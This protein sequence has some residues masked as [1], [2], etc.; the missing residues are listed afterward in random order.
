MKTILTMIAVLALVLPGM[1]QSGAAAG[2]EKEGVAVTVYN[3]GFGV[4][5]DVR[6]L[7]VGKDGVVLFKDVA[8]QIDS[9]TVHFKSFDDP[10]AKLLEQNYQYDLVSSDKLLQKYIDKEIEV[11]AAPKGDKGE[12]NRYAGKLLSFDGA[13]LVLQEKAG[14][15]VMVQRADNVR[16]I[17]F[18]ALPEGL[19]T[20]PTLVW[21][22]ATQKPG[23]QLAEVSYQTNG[24]TW[25]SEY[26]MVLNADD[27]AAGLN[28][29]VSV[30]NNS[31]KTYKDAHMKFIAGDVRRIQPPMEYNRRL[32]AM[33]AAAKP[34]ESGMVE[35]AFFEYHMYSLKRPSTVANN[36]VKQLELFE[37]VP[38]L[39]VQKLFLY[40]PMKGWRWGGGRSTEK[41][42][43]VTSDKKVTVF[44]EFENTKANN[45]GIPLPAG[46]VRV[47]KNDPADKSM[48][49]VGEEQIDHTANG[50]KLQLQ[51]GNA[52][53]ITGE[54][55]QTNFTV[56]SARREMTESFEITIYNSKKEDVTVRI[57]EPMF[58]WSGWKITETSDPN[59][60]KLDAFNVA[61]DVKVPAMKDDKRGQTKVTYTVEY[62]W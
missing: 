16:D 10:T 6:M 38:S 15:L 51:I 47:Y 23:K 46:K 58:R 43:G 60:K 56:D 48:E 18:S 49:F 36:E 30:Q 2:G 12:Q 3:G 29:W 61:W 39:K 14:G 54:R 4:V 7:D 21:Q 59:Y 50:E 42:Y 25:H 35:Q 19:L 27:T 55:K 8:Q 57:K 1:A 11:I 53:D 5:R 52:F 31:G 41:S 37:P 9:T 28:G 40:E 32:G 13:Q 62:R 33:P 17:R 44:V 45:L 20:Q 26:V 24:L 34:M 22:I